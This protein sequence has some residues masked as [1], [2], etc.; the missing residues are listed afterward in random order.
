MSANRM[1]KESGQDW[2]GSAAQTAQAES[3]KIQPKQLLILLVLSLSLAIIVIDATIVIVALPQIQRDFSISLKDLEWITS[4]YA[5]IF[6]SF[7]LSWGKLSDEYGRKLIFMSG[8]SLFI[9]GSI[10]DGFSTNLSQMLVGRVIQGFGAAMASPST[11][12]ILTTTFTGKSR[13]VAF[14][15]WGATAGAAAVLGP[16]LGGYFTTYISWRWAFFINIPIGI[17]ALVGAAV[18]IKETRFKDPKYT[19]DYPGLVLITIGLAS[20][21]FGLIEGQTYGWLVP[22]QDFSAGGFSWSTSNPL[23]LPLLSIITGIVLLGIFT[24]YEIRRAGKGLVPLFDFSLLRYKGFRYGLF[25]VT[26]VAMGE[27]G[28]VFIISIFLQTVKG[29]SAIDAGLTFLPMA[30]S[31]FIFAPV[32]GVLATRF[33]PKWIITTGMILESVALF[34]L[35]QIISISNPV[36]YL[37]PVL[38]IY[39]AGVGLAIS[40]VTSTVLMSIPWQKAGVGSGANNTV[41]QIGS[42]FGIAVIGAILVAQ[43]SSVGQADLA[44]SAVNFGPLASVLKAAFNSGLSGGLDQSLIASF[45]PLWPSA[46]DIIFDALTQGTRW[47]AFTAGIFVLLGALSSLLIPDPRSKQQKVAPKVMAEQPQT[48]RRTLGAI[49]IGQF[50]AILGLSAA[51]SSEYQSNLFMRDWFASYASPLGFLLGNYLGSMLIGVIGTVL[52]LW[53]LVLR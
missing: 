31:V 20:V 38:V 9:V 47:A 4:L 15:I 19:T 39:G 2:Q 33:G 42:A 49:V 12:S 29:L 18:V 27:F 10:I 37:Y 40:Q 11:L 30:I 50:L 35:S 7:L 25:T 13:N 36:Y 43:I 24:F 51:L 17:A 23:S 48:V 8:I 26:I 1:G 28:A 5:L 22:N 53:R 3:G 21:L 52:I 41:R 6:G 44:S 45:G 46:R 34:S 16:V 32:A 14:G